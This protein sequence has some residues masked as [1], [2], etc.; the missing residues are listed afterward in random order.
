MSN[1]KI[2]TAA[3]DIYYSQFPATGP[4]TAW[5]YSGG[6]N[7]DPEPIRARVFTRTPDS[8]QQLKKAIAHFDEAVEFTK[9]EIRMLS[10]IG[11]E[12]KYSWKRL[13]EHIADM[14]FMRDKCQEALNSLPWYVRLF[15]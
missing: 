10:S 12:S 5:Q 2:E 15:N 7:V 14:M 9:A 4:V 3:C 11:D 13:P 8:C 1:Y 6:L